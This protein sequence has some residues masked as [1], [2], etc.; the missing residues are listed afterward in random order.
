MTPEMAAGVDVAPSVSAVARF[1]PGVRPAA[2]IRRDDTGYV[3]AG[4]SVAVPA[5]LIATGGWL[6][7]DSLAAR[8]AWPE[9]SNDQIRFSGPNRGRD[10]RRMHAIIR[11]R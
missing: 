6:L 11:L 5:G 1:S 8:K 2:D 7:S 9:L 4:R 3:A 10:G